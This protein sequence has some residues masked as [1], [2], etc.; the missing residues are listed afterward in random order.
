MMLPHYRRPAARINPDVVGFVRSASAAESDGQAL[1]SAS[2][3]RG[4]RRGGMG[5]VSRC[6]PVALSLKFVLDAADGTFE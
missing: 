1:A 3:P 6:T 4:G 2:P 5:A